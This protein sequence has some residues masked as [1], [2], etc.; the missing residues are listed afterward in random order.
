M[1]GTHFDMEAFVQV[2]PAEHNKTQKRKASSKRNLG[3][4]NSKAQIKSSPEG[5]ETFVST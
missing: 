5:V 4:L 2:Q 1:L 3:I